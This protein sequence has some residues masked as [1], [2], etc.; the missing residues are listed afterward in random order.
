MGSFCIRETVNTHSK[1]LDIKISVSFGIDESIH[2]WQSSHWNINNWQTPATFAQ[3]ITEYIEPPSLF[4]LPEAGACHWSV[5]KEVWPTSSIPVKGRNANGW[6]DH[7]KMNLP[8]VFFLGSLLF[9][10]YFFTL[11]GPSLQT[12]QQLISV[13]QAD[14]CNLCLALE[15]V[16]D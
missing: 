10:N 3:P 14:I 8:G 13:T 1:V 7:W 9:L 12:T 2:L 11:L 4:T 5:S 15:M 16:S 6:N